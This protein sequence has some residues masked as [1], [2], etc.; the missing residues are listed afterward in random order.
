MSRPAIYFDWD[1]TIADSMPVCIGELS[2]GVQPEEGIEDLALRCSFQKS[3][4]IGTFRALSYDD[5][6]AIYRAANQ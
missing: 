2:C 6:Y 3:R 4:S 1:G 5:I